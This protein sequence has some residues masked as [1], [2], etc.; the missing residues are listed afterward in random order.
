MVRTFHMEENYARTPRSL[1]GHCT[2][3]V[4]SLLMYIQTIRCYA[5]YV[6]YSPNMDFYKVEGVY[7]LIRQGLLFGFTLRRSAYDALTAVGFPQK[8]D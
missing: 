3:R 8:H 5:Y 4:N 1:H 6:P 7:G 2:R